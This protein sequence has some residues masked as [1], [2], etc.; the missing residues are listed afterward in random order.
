MHILQ[1]PSAFNDVT[2]GNNP[3]CNTNGFTAAVGWD[4]D[5]GL[6]TPDYAKLKTVV[7]SLP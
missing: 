4:P 2:T 5:T 7:S 6:G 1:N 3:G